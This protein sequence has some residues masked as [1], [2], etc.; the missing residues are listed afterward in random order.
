M[1]RTNRNSNGGAE[2]FSPEENREPEVRQITVIFCDLVGSTGLSEKLDPEDLRTLIDAYRKTCDAAVR[3]YEGQ[4][5]NYS[6][7]GVMAFFGWPRAHED[8]AIRAVHAALTILSEI[9]D[10]PGAVTLASRVGI[11]SGRVVVGQ[12]HGPGGWIEAV[13]EAPNVAARLQML[14]APNTLLVADFTQDSHRVPSSLKIL[15]C[16]RSKA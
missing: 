10:I 11:C 5:A 9:T 4:V 16:K 8:D 15:V 6:G 2:A 14:A 7:D 13:G 1:S 3:R 12:T